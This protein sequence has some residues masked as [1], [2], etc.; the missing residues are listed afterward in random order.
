MLI[1]AGASDRT[2]IVGLGV[3]IQ[4]L[5]GLVFAVG[6][7]LAALA[8][9]LAAPLLAV[10]VGMGDHVLILTLVVVVIGGVG[11]VQGA[12]LAALLVGVIDTVGRVTL[13][14]GFGNIVI[15]VLMAMILFWRPRG[16]FPSNA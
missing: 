1:R 3:N 9:L 13:P 7:A 8:G 14:T 15:Y 5:Y 6:A 2:M 10:Q 4:L 12:L 11:S 16:L